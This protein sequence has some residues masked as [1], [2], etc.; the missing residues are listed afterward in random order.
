[1]SG[2]AT[3]RARRMLVRPGA[4]LDAAPGGYAVRLSPDRRRR[5][6][7]VIDEPAFTELAREPGLRARQAGG[8][9]LRTAEGRCDGPAPGRPGFIAGERT[10]AEPDGRLSRRAANLGESPIAWLARRRDNCGRPLLSPA[11]AAAGERLRTDAEAASLGPS[12]TMRWDGVPGYGSGRGASF[13]PGERALR[14]RARV[15]AALDAAGPG[16]AE[17]LE[18]ICIHGSALDAA[19]R[20]LGLPRRSGKT[21]LKLGLQRLAE[22]YRIG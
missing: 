4:W 20:G 5:P 13:T 21:V 18:R 19:E 12:L 1:M 16:L 6:A 17:I 8:W 15:R 2:R 10:V 3:A 22:H 9:A 7:L 14:A 11:E